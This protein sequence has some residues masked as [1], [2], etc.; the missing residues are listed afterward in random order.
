MQINAWAIL[1]FIVAIFCLGAT[2]FFNKKIKKL[3]YSSY[4]LLMLVLMTLWSLFAGIDILLVDLSDKLFFTDIS[5]V[6]YTMLIPSWTLFIFSYLSQKNQIKNPIVIINY[7]F[8]FICLLMKWINPSGIFYKD[9]GLI[10][11]DGIKI[12]DLTYGAFFWVYIAAT[13]VML[14]I[15]ISILIVSAKKKVISARHFMHILI[16]IIA[17]IACNLPYILKAIPFDATAFGYV[18]S[19]IMVILLYKENF[20]EHMPISKNYVLDVIYDGIIILN[21]DLIP[22]EYNQKI[23]NILPVNDKKNPDLELI[24]VINYWKGRYFSDDVITTFRDSCITKDGEKYFKVTIKKIFGSNGKIRNYFI[25]LEDETDI[26]GIKKRVEFLEKHDER[27][28]LYKKEYFLNRINNIIEKSPAEE[29]AVI[30]ITINNYNECLYAYGADITSKIM[31]IASKRIR[32]I[33]RNSDLISIFSENEFCVL[34]RIVAD[35]LQSF[36]KESLLELMIQ[37]FEMTLAYPINVDETTVNLK[38]SLGVS[39]YPDD[40]LNSAELI[41]MSNVARDN[42]GDK[43]FSCGYF[44]GINSDEYARK[45]K[46]ENDILTALTNKEFYL[47]YQ[48]QV[49]SRNNKVVGLEALIRWEHPKLGTIAPNDFIPVAEKNGKINAIGKWVLEEV[50][51]HLDFMREHGINDIKISLNVSLIQLMNPNFS[52]EFIKTIQKHQVDPKLLEVEITESY[53][54]NPEML[55][56]KHISSI[57]DAGIKIA[58]DDFGMG[59]SSLTHL[60]KI[61]VDTIKLDKVLSQD[62][63]TNDTSIKVIKSIVNMCEDLSLGIV[64]EWIEDKKQVEMLKEVGCYVIQG[65]YYSKP[66]LPIDSINFIMKN[67]K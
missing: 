61:D 38:V 45:I 23:F 65:F 7:L 22:V 39:F 6:V 62:I 59:H 49:D 40:S 48:P 14:V 31:V 63:L 33:I 50:I 51:R 35:D 18:V 12:L 3:N 30:S 67:N 26:Y 24:D 5:Y 60:N 13:Y 4:V 20:F 43:Q 56:H 52:K 37:R 47:V 41:A 53:A 34:I 15:Q 55:A 19:C 21:K 46:I 9:A 44:K 17:P 32:N 42:N 16:A 1:N 57:R 58:I 10:E 11:Q 66:L 27:T 25:L 2:V 29:L 28:G 8:F 64:V 54:M 36:S